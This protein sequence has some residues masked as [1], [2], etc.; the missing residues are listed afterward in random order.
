YTGRMTRSTPKILAAVLTLLVIGGFAYWGLKPLVQPPAVVAMPPSAIKHPVKPVEVPPGWVKIDTK[1]GFTFYAPPGT[2]FSP[3]EGEDSF[4]G[5]ITGPDF[6]LQSDFGFWSNDLSDARNEQDYSEEQVV[7]DGRAG[8]IRR[9][10]FASEDGPP[11]YFAGL[12]VQ[13][14]VF[15]REYPGRWAALEIHGSARTPQDRATVERM[16]KTV[17]FGE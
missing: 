17:Q 10:T 1:Q 6:G 16:L 3:L 9:A 12:Y 11:S 14:A 8:V 4:L 5:E 2:Q 13:Q 15:H 7:I